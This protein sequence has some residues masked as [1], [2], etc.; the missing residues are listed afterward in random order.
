MRDRRNPRHR[1]QVLAVLQTFAC[2][3]ASTPAA[4]D[5]NL[6]VGWYLAARGDRLAM[7]SERNSTSPTDNSERPTVVYRSGPFES[8][9]D[10]EVAKAKNEVVP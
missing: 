7:S 4:A 9:R 2:L 1:S 6:G 8:L 10:C 5:G 3:C